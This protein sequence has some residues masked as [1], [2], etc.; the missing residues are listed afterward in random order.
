MAAGANDADADLM[1]RF[2]ILFFL[3]KSFK[4]HSLQYSCQAYQLKYI[5]LVGYCYKLFCFLST[6]I[7]L[8]IHV[9]IVLNS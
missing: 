9:Y 6:C 3:F 4:N 7:L 1:A 8:H 2:V 5:K